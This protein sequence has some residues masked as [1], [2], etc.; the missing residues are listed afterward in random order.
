MLN[1]RSCITIITNLSMKYSID[2]QE[3]YAVLSLEDDKL[4][5]LVA[6]DLKSEFIVLKNEGLK[7]LILDMEHVDYVDS[8]GLSA[9]LTAN[10]LWSENSSF[11][12]CNVHSDSITK[13]IKISRLD[14]VFVVIP[15]LQEAKDYV[16]MEELEREINTD[17][18]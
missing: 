15:T 14:S 10:R 8:S 13:L 6:P 7:N 11:V 3:R 17:E 1:F 9:L 12:M 5:S 18:E 4:N 16:L 2:K